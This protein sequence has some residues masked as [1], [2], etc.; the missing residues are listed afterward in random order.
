[1]MILRRHD[2]LRVEPTAWQAML[3]CHP[4][5]AALPLVADWA[6]REWPVIVR[7]RMA[8][9]LVDD[10]PAALP[11]P[12]S[13]GKQRVAFGFSS[14]AAVAA[15]PPVLLVD[16]AVA[17]PSEWQQVIATL[18]ELGETVETRPRVFGALLWEHVTGL[19]YLTRQSDLDLLWTVSDEHAAHLIV[20]GL[21]RIDAEGPVRIDGEL[22]LPNGGGVNWRELAQSTD[23]KSEVLVKTMDAVEVRHKAKLFGAAAALS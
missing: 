15:L 7:R 9:D 20:A 16:A 10:V 22:V 23:L 6:L 4:D 19:Q 12:P 11:L 2:L 21:I 17:A 14:A 8:C 13:Y 3:R 5:L 18:L 1:V